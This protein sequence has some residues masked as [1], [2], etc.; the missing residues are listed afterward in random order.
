MGVVCHHPDERG[1]SL[2]LTPDIVLRELWLAI[3]VD[4]CGPVGSHG[5]SHAG[6]E[7]KDRTR[8]ALL[9]A[10]G[11][12]VIRLRLGATEGAQIGERDL[13]IESS[14]FTRA[15][16]TALL[17]AIEDYRQERPP[18][19]RVVPKGKTPATAA[20]RSH[21]VNIGLDRYSDDTYWFT[22]YPVLDEAEN[23]KY[24]LA[25]D[26]R[27]LYARTGRGSAFVAEVGL[28]Q[29]DRADWRARLTD[30][31][32]DKT[33]ASLRGTTKWP[34]GDTLLIPA[35]PDDQV[36]NEI[37]RASDHEKQTIDRIEFWFTISGD[38]IGGWTSDALRRADETP[39]VTIHPA[40]AALGYRFVEVTLDRGH[41]GSYQRITVS[42]AA[43]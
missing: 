8:N 24:R 26:G 43:A 22:W 40:A 25:A 5:Y 35:L 38:S 34:W 4:P 42:R 37:I 9:A 31:L 13:I 41:R 3:E 14:G 12:T 32:A 11:W 6:A 15:A 16:Q 27:Y 30:Y 29:V 19:V 7:E 10:V 17:E 21:V 28:H 1:R 36:G 18:R 2:T 39:I 23:H 20:R 33:P